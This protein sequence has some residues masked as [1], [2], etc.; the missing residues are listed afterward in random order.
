M[1]DG[2]EYREMIIEGPER[3]VRGF[4]LGV[5]AAHGHVDG[6]VF[7]SADEEI[8]TQSLMGYLADWVGIKEH[9]VHAIVEEQAATRLVEAIER[10]HHLKLE[11]RS[12]REVLEA[13]FEFRYEIFAPVYARR[14]HDILNSRAPGIVITGWNPE[15]ESDPDA[16]GPELYAPDHHWAERAHGRVSG[17]FAGMLELYRACR[18]EQLIRL[19]N[20]EL[21]FRASEDEE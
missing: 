21:R 20:L 19:G 8:N 5:I 4:V 15:V 16:R 12:D 17:S 7:F 9:V 10:D 13:S 2:F 6:R 11:L 3:L 1:T 14:V 18:N